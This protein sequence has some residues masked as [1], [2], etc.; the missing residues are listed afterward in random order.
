[1]SISAPGIRTALGQI[2]R[3]KEIDV[4]LPG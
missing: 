3:R 4:P 1:M 2:R